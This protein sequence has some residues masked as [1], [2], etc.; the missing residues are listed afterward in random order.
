MSQDRIPSE[1]ITKSLV[2]P[3]PSSISLA[4]PRMILF[5]RIVGTCSV[6]WKGFCTDCGYTHRV[7]GQPSSGANSG[8][9]CCDDCRGSAT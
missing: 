4:G 2:R 7:R 9:V 6:V 8:A 5:A 3:N 1:M